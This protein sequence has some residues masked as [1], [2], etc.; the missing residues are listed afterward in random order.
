M[1]DDRKATDKASRK[2]EDLKGRAKEAVGSATDD[3]DL[4]AEGRTD[5]ASAGVKE[6]L[7]V[8]RD[9]AEQVVDTVRE[10]VTGLLRRD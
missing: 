8:A 1:A 5:Q 7:D 3:D 4:R 10:K 9:K 6:K 2:A